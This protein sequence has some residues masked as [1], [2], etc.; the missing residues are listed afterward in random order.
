MSQPEC[1]SY[2]DAKDWF[3]RECPTDLQDKVAHVL[4]GD[5]AGEID[6]TLLE[7]QLLL[8]YLRD[9]VRLFEEVYDARFIPPSYPSAVIMPSAEN[10]IESCNQFF[11]SPD[12]P[13]LTRLRMAL[14]QFEQA[15][16]QT[17]TDFPKTLSALRKNLDDL[18][19]AMQKAEQEKQIL[20]QNR[21]GLN[22]EEQNIADLEG[23]L[24]K[25]EEK[26]RAAIKF[27]T[28][29]RGRIDRTEI[30]AAEDNVRKINAEIEN[31]NARIKTAK[32]QL[33]PN[34]F[35]LEEEEQNIVDL[36]SQL[37]KA[38]NQHSAAIRLLTNLRRRKKVSR[39][40]ISEAEDNVKKIET[41]IEKLDRKITR[42]NEKH[43]QNRNNFEK[44]EQNII[45]LESELEKLKKTHQSAISVL[46][47]LQG[48]I[49][50]TEISAAE[51]DVERTKAQIESLDRRIKRAK[52][53]LQ[54]DKI[55]LETKGAPA[56][57]EYEQILQ[58]IRQ[59]Q[60]ELQRELNNFHT[61]VAVKI[62]ASAE[63]IPV[64]VSGAA[65]V[66]L[67]IRRQH[68]IHGRT[69]ADLDE[70]SAREFAELAVSSTVV[71]FDGLPPAGD[72]F[73]AEYKA[74]LSFLTS[75]EILKK[76]ADGVLREF[77]FLNGIEVTSSLHELEHHFSAAPPISIQ[78]I[79]GLIEYLRLEATK[80]RGKTTGG[81]GRQ[82]LTALECFVRNLE[83]I[84]EQM[85]AEEILA[86]NPAQPW[87]KASET[88]LKKLYKPMT[89]TKADPSRI[90]KFL[91]RLPE[92]G[93]HPGGGHE[94]PNKPREGIDAAISAT[95]RIINYIGE[96][97][98][99]L[100]QKKP[101]GTST[102]TASN[103][104]AETSAPHH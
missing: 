18:K 97:I 49:G 11:A 13:G 83:H 71:D 50:K 65:M 27:L 69:S 60:V 1:V 22:R 15:G 61:A 74:K 95:E 63:K 102:P 9:S 99:K 45:D 7:N 41:E 75:T 88:V 4:T 67:C 87:E 64:P 89:D 12:L 6:D 68:E 43:K 90:K 23:E 70:A 82:D 32:E 42:A 48:Q 59:D 33:K 30:S 101:G 29:L 53:Q 24:Q 37:R 94:N 66:Y 21:S 52:A 38:K 56:R 14:S 40:E 91:Q 5:K 100:T 10:F 44:E 28:N 84:V 57:Q 77:P 80:E 25:A 96:L 8:R 35:N 19:Q 34:R 54:Q 85:I 17:K 76:T 16:G 2:E 86:G 81:I 98:K 92:R 51:S 104:A 39:R 46:T 78:Q 103:A 26:H 47:K 93:E 79:V 62:K 36:K 73:M 72:E 20:E 58:T 55:S 31:L 3:S